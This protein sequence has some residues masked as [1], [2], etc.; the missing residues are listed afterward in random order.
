MYSLCK[1]YIIMENLNNPFIGL[2]TSLLFTVQPNGSSIPIYGVANL[3]TFGRNATVQH[4]YFIVMY[5]K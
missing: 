4:K 5:V 1:S 2:I 3:K